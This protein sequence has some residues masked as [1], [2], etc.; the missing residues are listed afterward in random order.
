MRAQSKNWPKYGPV[1]QNGRSVGAQDTTVAQVGVESG[2]FLFNPCL[3]D[4]AWLWRGRQSGFII[5]V[6]IVVRALRLVVAVRD[7]RCS[8][9]VLLK[10]LLAIESHFIGRQQC[11]QLE[12]V[13]DLAEKLEVVTT[14]HTQ[15]EHLTL[16]AFT[17]PSVEPHWHLATLTLTWFG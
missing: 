14:S 5:V 11:G 16:L 1:S 6:I 9:G 12:C 15:R 13:A 8:G 4:E 10:L 3:S 7:A 17:C 2:V